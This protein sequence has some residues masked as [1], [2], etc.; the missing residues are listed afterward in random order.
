[1]FCMIGKMSVRDSLI[2]DP[3]HLRCF[4]KRAS[5]PNRGTML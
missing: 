1:M 3:E 4:K 5:S 2:D